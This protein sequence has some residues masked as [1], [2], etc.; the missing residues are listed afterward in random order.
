MEYIEC[1]IES[2]ATIDGDVDND[3]LDGFVLLNLIVG[4]GDEGKCIDNFIKTLWNTVLVVVVAFSKIELVKGDKGGVTLNFIAWNCIFVDI[5]T[6]V[7]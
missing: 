4:I 6:E 5:G 7:G 1:S 2:S 3:I